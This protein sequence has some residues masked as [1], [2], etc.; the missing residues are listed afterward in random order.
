MLKKTPLCA[1]YAR[2]GGKVV[3]YAGWALPVQY[4]GVAAEHR[5]VRQAAGLFDVSHMGEMQ[6]EG[7]EALPYLQRLLTLNCA[8]LRDNRAG[9]GLMLRHNGGC[10]DDVLVYKKNAESYMVVV[11][12]AN[13]EKDHGWMQEQAAGFGVTVTDVSDT[14]AQLALQGQKAEKILKSVSNLGD[15]RFFAFAEGVSVLGT[16]CLISRT[17]Y[18]GEDGF[19]L[20]AEPK[21]A[22][23]L[24][25]GLLKAGAGDGLV[26]CGLGARDTLR[27]EACLPLYGNELSEDITPLEAGL[28]RFVAMEKGDFIGRGA[29]AAQQAEGVKRH[30]IGLS[31]LEKGIARAGHPIVWKDTVAGRV[32]TGYWS[33]TLQDALAM[34]FVSCEAYEAAKDLAVEIRGKRVRAAARKMPFYQKQ[35]QKG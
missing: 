13:R 27:F 2:Y 10:V 8:R 6:V 32:T 24:F 34:A 16:R 19:E 30:L 11:N 1:L 29:L 3:D 12:A 15:L 20:Y 22:P 5:A 7:P 23:A 26:P 9:Y 4:E 21:D 28:G 17:G 35:Y 31:L 14:L 33:P 25:E 18:T